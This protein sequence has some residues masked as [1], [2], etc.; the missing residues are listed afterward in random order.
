[1]DAT[2]FLTW[3]LK[4]KRIGERFELYD[5][6]LRQIE[7][8]WAQEANCQG[9]RLID[10]DILLYYTATKSRHARAASPHP[11]MH[12]IARLSCL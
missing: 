10:M 1:L 12:L 9:P 8:Q 5:G 4:Q 7:T 2:W 11:S 3:P 6:A